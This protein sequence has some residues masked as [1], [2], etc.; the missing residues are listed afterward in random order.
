MLP[1]GLLTGVQATWFCGELTY[2]GVIVRPGQVQE[3]VDW[4]EAALSDGVFPELSACTRIGYYQYSD[5]C[6]WN[7]RNAVL[8]EV[9]NPGTEAVYPSGDLPWLKRHDLLE[10]L[11]WRGVVAPSW[12][13]SP[14]SM[15]GPREMP[16]FDCFS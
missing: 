5:R 4:I 13:L 9:D 15:G 8:R 7:M 2:L 3:A 14:W 12:M 1:L 16:G 10:Q 6:G 11:R